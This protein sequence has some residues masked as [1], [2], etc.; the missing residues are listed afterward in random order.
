M[1]QKYRASQL[2]DTLEKQYG[3]RFS[4]LREVTI[5]D[6]VESKLNEAYFY[7]TYGEYYA[8]KI[9]KRGI[10]V[11][12]LP[13]TTNYIPNQVPS[14]RRIDAIMSGA[15]DAY[16]EYPITAVEVKVSRADF[17]RDTEEKRRAWKSV[18]HRFI[19][20]VPKGLITPEET[21][22]GCGLWYWVENNYGGRIEVA[23]RAE[24]RHGP[25]DFGSYFAP[26]LIGRASR[27][28]RKLKSIRR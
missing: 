5:V 16:G 6:P 27:A 28:E 15:M 19:Y 17:K 14:S 7:R 9:K 18:T 21:P 11:D 2:L 20:L 3:S 12:N 26:Y 10:D 13:D 4:V 1:G 25:D 22:E 23:K 24:V 8:D